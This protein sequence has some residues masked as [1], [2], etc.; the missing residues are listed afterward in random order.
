MIPQLSFYGKLY[1]IHVSIQK[2]WRQEIDA[3][4]FSKASHF[5]K[6]VPTCLALLYR[7]LIKTSQR[8]L[9][10]SDQIDLEVID[11]IQLCYDH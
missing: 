5:V 9:S 8:L 4:I 10:N 11:Q 1:L 7:R 2:L 3:V 6:N